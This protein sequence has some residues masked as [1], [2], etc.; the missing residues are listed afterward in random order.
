MSISSSIKVK[1]LGI[2]FA[3]MQFFAL[4]FMARVGVGAE[5]WIEAVTPTLTSPTT[6]NQQL[7]T[8]AFKVFYKGELNKFT[9]LLSG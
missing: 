8:Q 5:I 1:R 9:S 7:T 4:F 3:C 2:F 6:V